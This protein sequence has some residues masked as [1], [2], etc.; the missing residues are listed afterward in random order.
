MLPFNSF[1]V[2]RLPEI[3]FGSGSIRQLP[4]ILACYGGPVLLVTG[5]SSFR[6]TIHWAS[7]VEK[8][9]ERGI[10]W[11]PVTVE[12]EP[13]PALVDQAV[14]EYTDKG[15]KAVAGIGGGSVLDAAKAIA[16]SAAHR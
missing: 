4:E 7:L 16:G 15:F 1:N 14:A 13:S 11:E 12:N 9:A 5:R 8:L 6:N 3:R 2:A 10:D